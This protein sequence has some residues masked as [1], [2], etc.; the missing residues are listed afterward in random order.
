MERLRSFLDNFSLMVYNYLRFKPVQ[1]ARDIDSCCC[2]S[3]FFLINFAT[4]ISSLVKSKITSRFL[5]MYQAR[6]II[7]FF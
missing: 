6:A 1:T 7:L 4:P 5:T 3:F 2:E